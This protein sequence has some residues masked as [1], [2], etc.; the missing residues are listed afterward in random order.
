MHTHNFTLPNLYCESETEL[1][2]ILLSLSSFPSSLKGSVFPLLR[3]FCFPCWQWIL[4]I[5]LYYSSRQNWKCLSGASHELCSPLVSGWGKFLSMCTRLP[6][7]IVVGLQWF[8]HVSATCRQREP[9]PCVLWTSVAQGWKCS[10][11]KMQNKLDNAFWLKSDLSL[12][13]IVIQL[14]PIYFDTKM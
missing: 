14:H 8:G 11:G 12:R 3:T 2:F 5:F 6:I 13:C 9:G 7:R 1:F 4:S 10:F